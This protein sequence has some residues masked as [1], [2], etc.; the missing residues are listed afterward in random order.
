MRIGIDARSLSRPK[1]G[2]GS[3]TCNLLRSL[4]KI[5]N[6]NQFFIYTCREFD[7]S[8]FGESD[9]IT[10]R[11]SNFPIGTLWTQAVLPFQL[12]KDKIDIFHSPE[13]MI[14]IFGNTPSI[15]TVNDLIS[16]LFPAGHDLKARLAANFYPPVFRKAKRL[17]A[18][19]E[20]TSMDIQ[21]RF[22]IS[23]GKISVVPISYDEDLFKPV[24]DPSGVL[25]KYDVKQPYILF[26]GVLSPRKN[27][28]RLIEAFGIILKR[29]VDINLVIAGPFGWQCKSVFD[30]VNN[31]G[32]SERIKFTGP[33]DS[34][35]L[36][37]IY[38]GA[39]IFVFPSLYEGFGIPVLE[40]MACGTPVITSNVSS[41]PEVAGDAALL[42]DPHSSTDLADAICRLIS[43]RDMANLLKTKGFERIKKY[44]WMRTAEETLK[45][46]RDVVYA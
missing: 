2:I 23:T 16:F 25:R 34:S 29:G 19:S 3:Y 46:Y 40:A 44:S 35:D 37:A 24:E 45:I 5:A 10:V 8:V 9:V 4:I 15:A 31:L 41:L 43:D 28:G 14:P 27:V 32:F 12:E 33:V 26:V 1:T 17:I 30:T 22:G 20:N 11:R 42:I 13:T 38:S 7:E 21:N 36:P 6:G 18:I 39:S